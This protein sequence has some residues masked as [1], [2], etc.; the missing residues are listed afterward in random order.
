MDNQ[1][2][3]KKRWESLQK[4][5]EA[6]LVDLGNANAFPQ[7]ETVTSLLKALK[8][9]A[10]TQFDFFYK[11]FY[12]TTD[13]GVTSLPFLETSKAFLPEY[14]IRTTLFQ[15]EYDLSVIKQVISQRTGSQ[16]EKEVLKKADV[17]AYEA[18]KPAIE[19]G[20]VGETAVVTYF[21]KVADVRVIP[22][23]PIALIG[24]PYSAI[25]EFQPQAQPQAA[26]A[27]APAPPNPN[28]NIRDFLAIPH[29]IG[30]Y[31]YWHGHLD[32]SRL[33]IALSNR[34]QK[35]ADWIENWLEE[36]VADVYG[37]MIVG[38]AMILNFQ[39]LQTNFYKPSE[40]TKDDGHHPIPALRPYIYSYTLS[41]IAYG[42][43]PA[44]ET[45]IDNLDK[46]WKNWLEQYG[47]PKT[48]TTKAAD[49]KDGEEVSIQTLP[50]QIKSIID[51]TISYLEFGSLRTKKGDF[52]S[53]GNGGFQDLFAE[54]TD[55][56][57]SLDI[58]AE[59][60]TL[61]T[62]SVN[63]NDLEIGGSRWA[64][65]GETGLAIDALKSINP[66][67]NEK[68][69]MLPEAWLVVFS[70]RRWTTAGPTGNPPVGG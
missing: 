29:E 69:K 33:A 5:M 34:L 70:M 59:F 27:A 37:A 11:G 67:K 43:T 23:A 2:I 64:T 4:S 8:A 44:F 40:F 58:D 31:V 41:K 61:P 35:L 6:T 12:E 66:A 17:L 25:D 47:I 24:L 20:I 3:S 21:N 28:E 10:G 13:N 9:F 53:L 38:P 39:E 52:W 1:V 57:S 65:I 42:G 60:A 46:Q 19:N 45:I 62:V 30:H 68:Y 49:D 48:F 56:V 51:E 22:Y 15:V 55:Y 7:K 32:R 16:H 50:E 18:I 63:G 14:V 54:F 36:I 26:G